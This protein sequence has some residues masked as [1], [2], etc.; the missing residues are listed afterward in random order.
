[1]EAAKA[2]GSNASAIHISD[3]S[4]VNVAANSPG[5]SQ[6]ATVISAEERREQIL[7]VAHALDQMR[8]ILN[9]TPDRDAQAVEAVQQLREVSNAPTEEPARVRSLMHDVHAIG[10]GATT[11]ATGAAL[12]AL[13]G[14]AMHALGGVALAEL[15]GAGRPRQQVHVGGAIALE[16]VR[17]D[18]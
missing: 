8:P 11:S 6:T 7:N 14:T 4:G 18:L 10:I 12:V 9:L 15:R 16:N 13:V 5:A 3:S 2:S 1:M 17:L